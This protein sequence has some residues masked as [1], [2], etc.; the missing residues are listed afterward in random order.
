MASVQ[1]PA[2]SSNISMPNS[3]P[4]IVCFVLSKMILELVYFP[5][6]KFL[7]AC[8]E[9]ERWAVRIHITAYTNQR[10]LILL[11]LSW[12]SVSIRWSGKITKCY[13]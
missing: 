10:G 13:I 2:I 1:R 12:R 7:S 9:I 4:Y 6:I 11:L 8:K 5:A 3:S